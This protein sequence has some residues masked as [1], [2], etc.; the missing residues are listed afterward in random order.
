MISF[1]ISLQH[2]ECDFLRRPFNVINGLLL[3]KFASGQSD[4]CSPAAGAG[5]EALSRL[6]SKVNVKADKCHEGLR[7][8]NDSV[9]VY[10]PPPNIPPNQSQAVCWEHPLA[11]ILSYPFFS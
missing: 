7:A 1:R 5:G 3:G 10:A 4:L 2:P 9:S 11:L 6:G 8:G